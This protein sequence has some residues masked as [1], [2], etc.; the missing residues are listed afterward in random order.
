M[1]PETQELLRTTLPKHNESGRKEPF[2]EKTCLFFNSF[3][4]TARFTTECCLETLKIKSG[5]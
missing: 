3:S 5:P 2:K 4:T 1:S